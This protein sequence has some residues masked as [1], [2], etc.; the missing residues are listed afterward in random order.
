MPLI[1]DP[2]VQF[3]REMSEHYDSFVQR[4]IPDYGRIH[5]L[6]VAQL[7]LALEENARMLVVGAGTCTEVLALADFDPTWRF[8]A[9]E[10]SAP[11]VEVA[12]ERIEAAG[13]NE[14]VDYHVGT[15]DTL[16]DQGPFDAATTILMMQFVPAEQKAEIFAD[17]GK[18]LK[19]QAPLVMA[20]MI[21]DPESDEH[22]LAMQAWRD[23]IE[24]TLKDK[25][26]DV[27]ANV[28]ET[29]HFISDEMQTSALKDVGFGEVVR[30]HTKMMFGAWIAIKN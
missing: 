14:R 4:L 27:F 13:L 2:S 19:S 23:H 8:T 12:R 21:G 24:I 28:S 10:P 17:I 22:A 26:A 6:V 1:I 5:E 15:L 20:H 29:L 9:V 16:D 25:A 30:F 18:R 3:D 11:M 7:G